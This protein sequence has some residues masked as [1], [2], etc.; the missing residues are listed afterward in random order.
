MLSTNSVSNPLS[1]IITSGNE[2]I[3]FNVTYS[4]VVGNSW[5][6]AVQRASVGA[7]A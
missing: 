2:V 7:V 5:L 3:P 6:S 1:T 4:P